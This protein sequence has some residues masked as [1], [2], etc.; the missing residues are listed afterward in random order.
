MKIRG[1]LHYDKDGAA[2]EKLTSARAQDVNRDV[3]LFSS[4]LCPASDPMGLSFRDWWAA[5]NW[6]DTGDRDL[7]LAVMRKLLP[8][9]GL[10]PGIQHHAQWWTP[11]LSPETSWGVD[12]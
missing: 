8:E 3:W 10:G 11:A 9:E 1:H 4:V 6:P 7:S 5:R 2:E 12:A